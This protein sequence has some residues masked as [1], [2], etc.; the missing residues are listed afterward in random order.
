MAM[1][2]LFWKKVLTDIFVR[3]TVL[4]AVFL[5]PIFSA[6]GY[7]FQIMDEKPS[8]AF[9]KKTIR[10]I[11]I[12]KFDARYVKTVRG[13]II[14]Y[15]DLEN[16]FT[17][18][19]IKKFYALPKGKGGNDISVSQAEL[20]LLVDYDL[21]KEK[22]QGGLNVHTKKQTTLIVN[23]A[24]HARKNDVIMFGYI[25]KFSFGVTQ[26]DKT[27]FIQLIVYLVD[28]RDGVVLWRS[29][30]KGYVGD[31]VHGLAILVGRKK[32][33]AGSDVIKSQAD[34][35]KQIPLPKW[36]LYFLGG[37]SFASFDLI[38]NTH[39]T[40]H[41]SMITN[42]YYAVGGINAVTSIN[43]GG[44]LL[45]GVRFSLL[46]MGGSLRPSI[47]AGGHIGYSYYPLWNG[48]VV[49]KR[50][51]SEDTGGETDTESNMYDST[52]VTYT[53]NTWTLPVGAQIFYRLNFEKINVLFGVGGEF[54]WSNLLYSINTSQFSESARLSTVQTVDQLSGFGGGPVFSVDTEF[55]FS[56][57]VYLIMQVSGKIAWSSNYKGTVIVDGA[58]EDGYILVEPKQAENKTDPSQKIS[59]SYAVIKESTSGWQDQYQMGTIDLSGIDIRVGIGIN[60][61]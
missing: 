45:G 57:S 2:R 44:H 60:F 59:R 49:Y 54:I 35:E 41:Q 28:S 56:E 12:Q 47:L 39:S 52:R 29:R 55:M 1:N 42:G 36:S 16:E 19:L 31:V 43:H 53:S 22:K 3:Y 17:D 14:N 7:Y 33:A 34:E 10:S 4:L 24:R 13:K 11:A 61:F 48:D 6:H 30:V 25:E 5:F 38:N 40:Y 46:D 8:P 23:T 26:S 27:N 15:R 9:F 21:H 37:Y 51:G 32:Y 18:A 58:A 50:S 20:P